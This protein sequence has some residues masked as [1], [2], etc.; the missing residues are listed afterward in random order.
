MQGVVEYGTA[1]RINSYNIPVQKAGKTGT[2]NGN[3]D[4][5]FIGYTPELLAGTWVGC[6]DPFIPIYSSNSGG[7]E[8]AAPKWGL[9]MSN[10]YADSR[11]HYGKVTSFEQPAEFKNN[12]IYADLNFANIATSGDSLNEEMDNGSSVDFLLEDENNA[13]KKSG[14]DSNK[15]VKPKTPV[16][17]A[18]KKNDY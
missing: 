1:R 12:P 10:V 15:K 6:E 8:M 2:T 16:L 5:W 18:T 17:P 9:F 7:A 4:G 3:T 13:P 14:G 11:L